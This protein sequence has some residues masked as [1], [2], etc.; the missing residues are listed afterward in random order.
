MFQ[1]TKQIYIKS[2][3]GMYSYLPQQSIH[4]VYGNLNNK[5]FH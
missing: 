1:T 5:T 2:P 4:A 3:K